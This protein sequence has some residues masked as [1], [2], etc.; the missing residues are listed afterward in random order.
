MALWVRVHSLL[1]IQPFHEMNLSQVSDREDTNRPVHLQ[2]LYRCLEFRI[3]DI[4]I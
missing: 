4:I 1:M 3:Y 2:K